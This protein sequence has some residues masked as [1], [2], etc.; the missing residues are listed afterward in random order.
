MSERPDTQVVLEV[1][2][3]ERLTPHLVR[4]GFTSPDLGA[5]AERPHTDAYVK[6]LFTDPALGLE[7]PYDLAELKRSL[8]KGRRP[9]SRTYTVRSRTAEELTIDFVVHGDEGVAGRWAASAA[10][11][12]RVAVRSTGGRFRPDPTADWHLFAG[13]EA[14]LP[15]IASGLEALPHDGRGVALIE[16]GGPRDELS[17]AHPAGVE[18]RWLHRG[19]TP[20]GRS[21][22]LIDAVTTLDWPAGTVEVFAHGEKAAMRVLRRHLLRER[23][24]EVRCLSLSRYWTAG[25]GKLAPPPGSRLADGS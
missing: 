3:R 4:L 15:A 11:G 25:P 12:D 17:L 9:V 20:P 16:V 14:A 7:P 24:V 21:D 5:L 18:V 8:P 2:R 22:V 10:P 19:G 6:L 1:V 13:D 23:G